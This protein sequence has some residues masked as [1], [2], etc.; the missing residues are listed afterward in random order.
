MTVCHMP[1][2]LF[3]EPFTEYTHPVKIR[4]ETTLDQDCVLNA[5]VQVCRGCM[6][7]SLLTTCMNFNTPPLAQVAHFSIQE[8]RVK[9][10]SKIGHKTQQGRLPTDSDLY[11][12]TF[13]S[14]VSCILTIPECRSD[15]HGS[16][17]SKAQSVCSLSLLSSRVIGLLKVVRQVGRSCQFTKI[18]VAGCS[19]SAPCSCFLLL[20]CSLLLLLALALALA[21][22][23]CSLLLL[24]S[25]LSSCI[26][27]ESGRLQ[28]NKHSVALFYNPN[29]DVSMTMQGDFECLLDDDGLKHI[30]TPIQRHSER[31]G[32]TPGIKD[33]NM[34]PGSMVKT[35]TETT[36][37]NTDLIRRKTEFDSE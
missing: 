21:P 4:T 31:Q 18:R 1:W 20:L 3:L 25:L 6:I 2:I 37:R 17:T 10:R 27:G 8:S 9:R 28:R 23:S 24:S 22:C 33:S 32:R 16:C 36:R 11:N 30:N 5:T 35:N 13:P 34:R 26:C 29:Q 14:L 12:S 7:V 15:H 19:C